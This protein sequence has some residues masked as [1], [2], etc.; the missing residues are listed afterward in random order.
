MSVRLVTSSQINFTP[1]ALVN[2][3]ALIQ[4]HY[5]QLPENV[6]A[7]PYAALF[8]NLHALMPTSLK[9]KQEEAA[10]E[11]PA[12]AELEH[13]TTSPSLEL[14]TDEAAIA[15]Y[16]RW[17]LDFYG[18]ESPYLPSAPPHPLP[19]PPNL[20][21]AVSIAARYVAMNGGAAAELRLIE[22]NGANCEFLYPQS[23]YYTYYQSRVR[24]NLWTLNQRYLAAQA[25]VSDAIKHFSNSYHGFVFLETTSLLIVGSGWSSATRDWKLRVPTAAAIALGV[26]HHENVVALDS[27]AAQTAMFTASN[28]H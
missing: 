15:D 2:I 7:N 8:K 23:A 10:E 25:A 24:H 27:R 18:R 1:F 21:S 19:P 28:R 16:N 22:H 17:H 13:K 3:D 12:A 20:A 6:A 4:Q 5:G 14:E 26:H 11:K 9:T